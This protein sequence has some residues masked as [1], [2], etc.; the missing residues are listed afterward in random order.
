VVH[1]PLRLVD[2]ARVAAER[3]EPDAGRTALVASSLSRGCAVDVVTSGGTATNSWL[4]PWAGREVDRG[5][6]RR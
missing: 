1:R 6:G 5:R 2:P 4:T 3:I